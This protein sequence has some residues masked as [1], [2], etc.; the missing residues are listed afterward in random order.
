MVNKKDKYKKNENNAS[1]S[2]QSSKSNFV[3][4]KVTLQRDLKNQND[5]FEEFSSINDVEA[6][7]ELSAS[8]EKHNEYLI[9]KK[10]NKP[11]DKRSQNSDRIVYRPRN[12]RTAWEIENEVDYGDSYSDDEDVTDDQVQEP[13]DVFTSDKTYLD[14][15]LSDEKIED[16]LGLDNLRKSLL[17]ISCFKG[18][19]D[20][21]RLQGLSIEEYY[22]CA[23]VPKWGLPLYT[24]SKSVVLK[25]LRIH[26][27]LIARIR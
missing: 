15:G 2:K 13:E 1:Q 17:H 19:F 6:T 24:D 20:S 23:E 27:R 11:L 10:A 18:A 9:P 25:K 7:N 14:D 16:L 12:F 8:N 26:R 5:N 4:E 21:M 3:K 22:L